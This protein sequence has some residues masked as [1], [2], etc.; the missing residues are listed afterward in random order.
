MKLIEKLAKEHSKHMEDDVQM[1]DYMELAEA[2]FQA[3]F[4]KAREMAAM[5][6]DEVA[7]YARSIP[8]GWNLAEQASNMAR[9]FRAMGEEE[10]N[11]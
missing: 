9:R 10:R 8:G 5:H 1:R 7:D 2:S 6:A 11:E 4:L 3:G